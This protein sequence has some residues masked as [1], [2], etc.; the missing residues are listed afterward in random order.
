MS[1][2][3]QRGHSTTDDAKA[4]L[5]ALVGS[6]F[7]TAFRAWLAAHDPATVCGY[8]VRCAE[9]PLASFIRDCIPDSIVRVGF[10]VEVWRNDQRLADI[11]FSDTRYDDFVFAIDNRRKA[12]QAITFREALAA[13][14]GAVAP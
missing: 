9:C 3:S 13:W 7:D 6:D 8:A 14:D 4:Q 5:D 11:L 10:S 1:T 2:N 12:G